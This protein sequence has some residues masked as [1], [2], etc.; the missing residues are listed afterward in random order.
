MQLVITVNVMEPKMIQHS[1]HMLGTHLLLPA[2]VYKILEANAI[3]LW[4]NQ[5]AA[6]GYGVQN[7]FIA[8]QKQRQVFYFNFSTLLA[9]LVF[10]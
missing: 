6:L 1:S 5:L 4:I 7:T 2:N 10:D 9:P 8:C 3:N